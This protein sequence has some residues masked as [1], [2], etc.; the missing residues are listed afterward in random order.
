MPTL[1]NVRRK[2]QIIKDSDKLDPGMAFFW[3]EI[4]KGEIVPVTSKERPEGFKV[5]GQ[6][7]LKGD[8]KKLDPK[9]LAAKY[10]ADDDWGKMD[11]DLS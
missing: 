7:R 6:R 10:P 3:Y 5:Y 4:R 1:K 2:G 11:D 8:D 9:T